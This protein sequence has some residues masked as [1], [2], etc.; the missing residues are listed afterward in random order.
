MITAGSFVPAGVSAGVKTSPC[1][2]T[3][4]E[5]MVTERKAIPAGGWYSAARTG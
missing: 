3:P 5:M 2:R 1:S 4:S